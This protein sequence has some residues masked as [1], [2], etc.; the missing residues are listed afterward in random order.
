VKTVLP[1]AVIGLLG[2]GENSPMFAAVARRMGYRVHVYSSGAEAAGS[3]ADLSIQAPYED[4]D[5]VRA[6]A[7]GVGV[8]TVA[9]SNLPV[10]ALRAAAGCSVLRPSAAVFEAVES[11]IGT[12][13]DAAA[14]VIAEFAVIGVRGVN[15]ASAVY[16][17][18]AI[19]RVDDAVDIARMPSPVD[20]R[21]ARR[22]VATTRDMLEDLDLTGVACVEFLL[23]QDLELLVQELTPHPHRSGH[24][25]IDACVT[26]QFEQQL[27]AVC[28]LPLGS[29]EMLRPAATAMLSDR[30]GGN[31]EPDW[32]AACA[33]PGVKLHLYGLSG[34][35]L[36]ATAA[37]AARAK[38]IVR[39]ARASLTGPVP[40]AQDCNP[41]P[42]TL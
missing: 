32:A 28:G 42:I 25:T 12:K 1:G 23:A 13:R 2:G 18:I 8:V 26:S 40:R 39:A 16:S 21:V 10:I 9:E 14:G 27:R 20:A 7:A 24:L 4:L 15:G 35:H 6:F 29:T 5:R 31:G 33:F 11:G 17:P 36:T 38:Q 41:A 37:S 34:G 22:A 3:L 19:D 30:A